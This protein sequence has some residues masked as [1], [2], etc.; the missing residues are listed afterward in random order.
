MRQARQRVS[1]R[2]YKKAPRLALKTNAQT[3]ERMMFIAAEAGLAR[4]CDQ[5]KA[6][7]GARAR[8]I[9]RL[10]GEDVLRDLDEI[11]QLITGV[12]LFKQLHEI[13]LSPA[14]PL[15]EEQAL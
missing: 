10:G 5:A 3:E 4:I 6:D 14:P 11:G 12:D 8:L 2:I 9:E 1:M 13:I 15:G 7:D